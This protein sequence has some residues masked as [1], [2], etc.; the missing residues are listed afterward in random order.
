M[1]MMNKR[2]VIKVFVMK[3]SWDGYMNQKKINGA[4]IQEK[5]KKNTILKMFSYFII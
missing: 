1:M 2:R 5:K 4:V 3:H